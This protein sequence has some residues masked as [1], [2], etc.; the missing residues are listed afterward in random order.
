MKEF[1]PT[2]ELADDIP[3]LRLKKGTRVR[4]I[5]PF[6][7]DKYAHRMC[8]EEGDHPSNPWIFVEAELIPLPEWPAIR[9][10]MIDR[11]TAKTV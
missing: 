10:R 9:R 2:H 11:I 5:N 4:Q 6:A 7:D 8:L 3:E 1:E